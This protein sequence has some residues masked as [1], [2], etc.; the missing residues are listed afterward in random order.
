MA[1]TFVFGEAELA[2]KVKSIVGN[3]NKGPRKR[4]LRKGARVV[5]REAKKTAAFRD[6]TGVLR[7]SLNLIPGLNKSLDV[8]VGPQKGKDKRYDGYYAQMVFDSAKNFKS[9]VLDPA[10][11]K[12]QIQVIQVLKKEADREIKKEAQKLN[13]R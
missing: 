10:A 7:K 6:R 5:V 9:R 13:L 12:S 2:E 11:K 8:F 3:F 1:R 4:I